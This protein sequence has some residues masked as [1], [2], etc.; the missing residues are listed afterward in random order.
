M[1]ICISL[2]VGSLGHH[3]ITKH[4]NCSPSY[5]TVTPTD[6]CKQP[7]P[8]P[9]SCPQ[10]RC[11]SR[12]SKCRM[13]KSKGC[14]NPQPSCPCPPSHQP[15]KK[16][17]K[18]RCCGIPNIDIWNARNSASF[19]LRCSDGREY[20][21]CRRDSATS[22]CSKNC[23]VSRKKSC[24]YALLSGEIDLNRISQVQK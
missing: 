19:D 23:R 1:K 18:A 3:L 10:S 4:P 14:I 2:D 7:N 9:L 5:Y 6:A 21:L 17:S 8:K 16:S 12:N 11:E 24:K 13:T 22:Q 20:R 15:S